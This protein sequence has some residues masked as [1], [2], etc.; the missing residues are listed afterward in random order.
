MR[1]PINRTIGIA[2]VVLF[3][4]N[5]VA[6][7]AMSAS[8]KANLKAMFQAKYNAKSL[9]FSQKNVDKFLSFVT[10][11]YAFYDADGNLATS[12]KEEYREKLVAYFANHEVKLGRE[13]IA[14][15]QPKAGGMVVTIQRSDS[16]IT[17]RDFWVK[18]N[19]NWL[20]KQHR[21]VKS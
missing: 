4:L 17:N 19:G 6:H 12:S 7:A 10:T 15:I 13:P 8:E 5:V 21:S 3:G 20:I 14:D 16:G 1:L 2:I 18:V 9:A 11:D